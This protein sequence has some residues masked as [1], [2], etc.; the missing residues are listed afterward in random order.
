MQVRGVIVTTTLMAASYCEVGANGTP[1]HL[2]G[3]IADAAW[4]VV[5]LARAR[6]TTGASPVEPTRQTD[7]QR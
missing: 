4:A 3:T 6:V 7:A 5:Q 2:Y 1:A